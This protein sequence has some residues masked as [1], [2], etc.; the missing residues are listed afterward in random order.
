MLVKAAMKL[1][2]AICFFFGCISDLP[3]CRA[4]PPQ[5]PAG[6]NSKTSLARISRSTLFNPT[7][8]NS[9]MPSQG[10]HPYREVLVPRNRRQQDSRPKDTKRGRD[11]SV[12]LV[13]SRGFDVSTHRFKNFGILVPVVLAASYIQDFF[14]IIALRIET[15]FWAN[16]PPSCYR[17]FTMWDFELIFRSA[18]TTI[19]WD[20]IQEY[21][22]DKLSDVG[23]G[24][25]GMFEEEMVGILNGVAAAVSIE[26]KLAGVINGQ[27]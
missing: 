3:A 23:K 7:L 8:L 25:T 4:N 9:H 14:D 20:F 13:P 15:G 11:G 17:I 2:W 21:V 22:V 10:Y 1:L 27:P 5:S 26:L 6:V 19:P 24:F 12:Q 18:G 16:E